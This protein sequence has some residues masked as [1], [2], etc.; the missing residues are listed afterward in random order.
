MR[1]FLDLAYNG[2][3]YHGWQVQKNATTVQGEFEKA[4]SKLLRQPIGV[5]GSGRT[6][7]GVHAEQ[8]LVHID[9]EEELDTEQL[10]FRLNALLPPDIAVNRIFPV[11]PKAHAR[12]S[13][14]LRSYEYRICRKKNPFLQ[15]LCYVNNRALDVAA[16]NRAA[17][18]LLPWEDFECFSR[19]HTDVKH[20]RCTI[21]EAKWVEEGGQL[22][23]YIQA[24][25]FLR[26]MVR[27]IVGTLLEV[28]QYRMS[29]EEF[30]QV[31]ESRDRSKAGRSAPAQGLFL[32]KV[33]YPETIYD[34]P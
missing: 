10:H 4:L 5:I 2:T 12:F 11:H 19:V 15:K 22:I 30:Q 25:R 8:Q 32:T 14:L 23:F 29:L 20:F 3:N 28:G 9:W 13:A 26:N 7:T 24:N 31:L 16:M 1:Y 27:A 33:A 6:D 18:L 21:K 17:A 34:V